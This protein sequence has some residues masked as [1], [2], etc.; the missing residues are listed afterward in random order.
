ML[1]YTEHAALFFTLSTFL[2]LTNTVDLFFL[3]R[4]KRTKK[5]RPF[6]FSGVVCLCSL[7]C[8][9]SRDRI[10][11]HFRTLAKTPALQ[12]EKSDGHKL[13]SETSP[14]PAAAVPVGLRPEKSDGQD[15]AQDITNLSG[16]ST[17]RSAPPKN[18]TD[19]FSLPPQKKIRVPQNEGN[20][21]IIYNRYG[22]R[23]KIV[24]LTRVEFAVYLEN[25]RSTSRGRWSAALSSI[26]TLDLRTL[27]L[28]QPLQTT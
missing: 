24:V 28:S 17:C 6:V 13:F 26:M 22:V 16:S 4:T 7:K 8:P 11:R 27:T 3:F 14:T 5:A 15:F 21:Y 25:L 2:K 18:P 10:G 19:K 12:P 23:Y 20:S 1:T 9:R